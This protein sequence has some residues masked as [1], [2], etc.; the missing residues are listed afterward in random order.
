MSFTEIF[1]PGERFWREQRQSEDD[2]R[3]IVPAP[4]PGPNDSVVDLA[5]GT[6]VIKPR[7]DP[8]TPAE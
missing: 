8:S 3:E 7:V 6:A 4:G 1:S 2:H 5:R